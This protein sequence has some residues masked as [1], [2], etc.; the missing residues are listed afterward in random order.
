MSLGPSEGSLALS[1][2]VCF[3]LTRHPH[4]EVPI[5]GYDGNWHL[6]RSEATR[7]CDVRSNLEP[8]GYGWST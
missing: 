2:R 8:T 4:P 7:N 5:S 1:W 6:G 3:T